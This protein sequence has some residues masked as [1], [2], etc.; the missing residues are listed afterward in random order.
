MVRHLLPVISNDELTSRRT[1]LYKA[2]S[3]NGPLTDEDWEFGPETIATLE[4]SK[5]L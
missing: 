3:K 1:Y 5:I 2:L 4:S